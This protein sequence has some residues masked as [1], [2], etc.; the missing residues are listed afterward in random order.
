[1]KPL[2]L[3]VENLTAF[4]GEQDLLDLSGHQLFAISGPT[5]AGK[6]SLLDAMIFALYGT[7]PRVGKSVKELISQGRDRMYV[8]LDFARGDD[9][10]FGEAEQVIIS[11]AQRLSTDPASMTDADTQALRDAGYSDRQIVDIT[12]AAAARNYFSRALLARAVPLDEVPGLG[13]SVSEALRG[14]ASRHSPV[15]PTADL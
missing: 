13:P 11:Y 2:R 14:A 6:S 1:M 15:G 4:R 3:R 7:V 12:L 10:A 5:G 9:S 8:R